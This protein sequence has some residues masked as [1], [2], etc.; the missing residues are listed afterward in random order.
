[1]SDPG[2][3][4]GAPEIAEDIMAGFRRTTRGVSARF[5]PGQAGI[6]RVAHQLGDLADQVAEYHR[7]GGG[8]AGRYPA[9]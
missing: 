6:R 7:L 5:T 8:E 3:D 4:D 1:M 2:E 9:P